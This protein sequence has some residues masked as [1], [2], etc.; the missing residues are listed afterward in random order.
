MIPRSIFKLVTVLTG[1]V[2]VLG[3]ALVLRDAAAGVEARE[4]TVAGT[5]V[6]VFRAARSAP[7]GSPGDSPVIVISHG[8][9]GSQQLMRSYALT[10][11]RR[12]YIAVTFDF[13]GHGRH[14]E[15]LRGDVTKI[16][17][18]TQMLVE[19]T[20]A[21]IDWALAL[22]GSGG[23]LA[24]LG[25]SMAS[26]IVVRTAIR[27]P[28]VSATVAISMFSTAVTPT[29]PR[30][31]LVIVGGLEGFLKEEAMRVLALA[32]DTPAAH[33][34]V[35]DV[36][37]GSARRV[38]VADGV[39]HVGVLYSRDALSEASA[40]LDAVFAGD[41]A[42]IDGHPAR[43]GPAIVTLLLGLAI[44]CWPLATL[45]PRVA[46][47]PRGAAL[48][49]RRLLPTALVPAVATPLLLVSF[50][51]D[52]LGVLVGGYLA[53]HF[54]LYGLLATGMLWLVAERRSTAATGWLS[55]RRLFLTTAA[56]TLF[57]AGAFAWVLDATVTSFAI[58]ATRVPLLLAT[59]CGTLAYFLADE[60]MAHGAGA[61]RGG[62]LFTRLCF[63]L[64]LAIAVALSFEDLFFL[65]IIAAVIVVYFLIYGLFSRWV[66]AATGHPAVGAVASAVS[67]AW[68]LAA[69]FP[70]IA[71]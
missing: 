31:L 45:L 48:P 60:W 28:R 67:F 27:D 55:T 3:A 49:W 44:L 24:L 20:M 33:R 71:G 11:A 22:P 38:A 4:G 26:D 16:E 12:G 57:L 64:S 50:P 65:V 5:P 42:G 8:F 63:L 30:N 41:R 43:R 2:L 52:A 29:Q 1:F 62:H 66:Y 53:M 58:T 35:G 70:L 34:T 14:P 10:L 40:W 18:A 17:G 19:Q 39:E 46:E 7:G 47:P 68:A 21:V 51:A 25:H 6:T 56:T 54:L 13:Y 32:T 9:A 69:V 61:V 23:E 15:V 36:A 37:D 59:L